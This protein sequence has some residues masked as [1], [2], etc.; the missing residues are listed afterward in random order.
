[1]ATIQDRL[2][3]AIALAY[4]N[5]M[6]V[7]D[8]RMGLSTPATLSQPLFLH[9]V[10]IKNRLGR[11]AATGGHYIDDIHEVIAEVELIIKASPW[12]MHQD[13]GCVVAAEAEHVGCDAL[14]ASSPVSP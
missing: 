5:P 1:M 13:G 12:Q 7:R 9:L 3:T 2:A 14:D 6:A 8:I 11:L 4:P 10:A